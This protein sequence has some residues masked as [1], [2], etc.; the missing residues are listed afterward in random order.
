MTVTNFSRP[1]DERIL[2]FCQWQSGQPKFTTKAEWR[3]SA[4][5]AGFADIGDASMGRVVAMLRDLAAAEFHHANLLA[6]ET[7]GKRVIEIDYDEDNLV[8]TPGY[9]DRFATLRKGATLNELAASMGTPED[10]LH[11]AME[12]LKLAGCEQRGGQI[13]VSSAAID[14]LLYRIEQ[15]EHGG[16][17]WKGNAA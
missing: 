4:D 8:L 3:T 14:L 5:A 6:A 1:S 11:S 9:S 16:E 12:H 2:E 7:A 15:L 10:W 13:T 17:P